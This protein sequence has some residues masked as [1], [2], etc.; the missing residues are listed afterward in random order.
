[1]PAPPV[2]DPVTAPSDQGS[3]PPPAVG[4]ARRGLLA[5]VVGLLLALGVAPS[6]AA[7]ATPSP[8]AGMKPARRPTQPAAARL[9]AAQPAGSALATSTPA[10][11]TPAT[12]APTTTS[13]PTSQPVA[14]AWQTAWTSPMDLLLQPYPKI[15]AVNTTVRDLATVTVGGSAIAIRLSNQ[16]GPAPVTFGAVT[17]GERAGTV[18]AA[19]V[20]GTLTRVTFGAGSPAITVPAGQDVTSA[21]IPL[22]VS[23][24]ESLVVSLWVTAPAPVTVHYCQGCSRL[25]FYTPNG[26]G[27]QTAVAS[28]AAFTGSDPYLRWLSAVEVQGSP[29]RGTVVALGDSITAGFEN[30]G[31]GWPTPLQQRVA[32]L[33]PDQQVSVVN[34]GISGNTLTV[35]PPG[36]D[37][38]GQPYSFADSSGGT[39]GVLRLQRDALALPGTTNVVLLL[40]TNDIWFGGRDQTP[41]YG[42]ASSII[43]AMKQVIAAVHAAGKRIEGIT[44]LPR[45]STPADCPG[46]L[47][48]PWTPAE[49]ATL[50]AVNSW[51]RSKGSGFD[52]VI[53]LA[54]VMGDVY[55]GQCNP[56]LPYPPYFNN[57]DLHPNR[58]GQIVMADAIPTTIFGIPEAPQLPPPVKATPTPGCPAARQAE[59]VLAAASATP[60][61]TTP[62]TTSTPPTSSTVASGATAHHR[63]SGSG[64]GGLMAVAAVLVAL[65]VVTGAGWR[66]R[67]RRIL[68]RPSHAAPARRGRT[69]PARPG[70]RGP[71]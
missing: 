50:Q 38:Q 23:A 48:E 51:M 19:V 69:S 14:P 3:G 61:T 6:L 22:A 31:F 5:L 63:G 4:A 57:D 35:F 1:M 34:E 16:W 13:P 67:R 66:R 52:A 11:S 53:D 27:N 25:A 56:T 47:P 58:A 12:S 49:Q 39:P 18:G 7:A 17:V 45:A 2:A 28:G 59:A 24:G 15:V 42:S 30:A 21:P 32:Q 26:G 46:C 71:P 60:A 41:P 43:A 20:A 64:S 36:L 44:L 68:R 33:P 70:W 9:A 10:T 65:V 55:D 8:P 54:A 37:A 40:G 29:S 62:T